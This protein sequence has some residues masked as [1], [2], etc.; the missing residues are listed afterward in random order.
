M[1]S[2]SPQYDPYIPPQS[3]AG[4]GGAAST[5]AP[6]NQRTAAL[7]AVSSLFI[8]QGWDVDDRPCEWPDAGLGTLLL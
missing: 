6:G 4:G 1:A 7:Q 8:F 3:S 5:A 2:S